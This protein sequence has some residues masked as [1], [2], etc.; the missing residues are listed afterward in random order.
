MGFISL[1]NFPEYRIWSFGACCDHTWTNRSGFGYL[2][3]GGGLDKSYEYQRGISA[4]YSNRD[5]F[6]GRWDIGASYCDRMWNR[7]DPCMYGMVGTG[8]HYMPSEV[9]M[10][11]YAIYHGPSV[12]GVH[13]G[14]YLL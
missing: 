2:G 4:L 11:S 7:G 1:D 6:F 14:A 13:I 3:V 8:V 5:S 10:C 9:G 12:S